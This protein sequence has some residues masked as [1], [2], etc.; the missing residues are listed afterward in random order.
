[1]P[2]K[3]NSVT[4]DCCPEPY[5]DITFTIHIRWTYI[6]CLCLKRITK[7]KPPTILQTSHPVL[8]LQLDRTLRTDLL[9]GSAWIHASSWFGGE[10]YIRWTSYHLFMWNYEY[11]FFFYL[12]GVEYYLFK[13]LASRLEFNFTFCQVLLEDSFCLFWMNFMHQNYNV[14]N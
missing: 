8:L 9:H 7:C 10:T 4:Y 2:G 13:F 3:K 1:M 14:R 5:V 12:D 11:C 6:S